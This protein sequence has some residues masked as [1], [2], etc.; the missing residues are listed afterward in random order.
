VAAANRSL[1]M[2]AAVFGAGGRDRPRWMIEIAFVA[3]RESASAGRATD[4][5]IEWCGA[6][7]LLSELRSS[8][9]TEIIPVI[10]NSGRELVP[11]HQ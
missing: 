5:A 6:R 1:S 11:I 4:T 3:V 7:R 9:R 2:G 8:I 10:P